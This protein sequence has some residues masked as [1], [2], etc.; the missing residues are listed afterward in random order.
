VKLNCWEHE[1]C[2][3]EPGG[4]NSTEL[5]VC[6]AS[7]ETRVDGMN[8][9]KNGGRACWAVAGTLCE[10]EVQGSFAAK[11]TECV[12]C[13]FYKLVFQEERPYFDSTESVLKKLM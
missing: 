6:P 3:R 5:G 13:D 8:S 1:K 11:C 4:I 7:V 2:G 9:G 12:N 10:G